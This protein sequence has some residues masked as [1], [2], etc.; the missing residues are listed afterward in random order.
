[1]G[2]ADRIR[3]SLLPHGLGL[4]IV[5]LDRDGS[6]IGT[7]WREGVDPSEQEALRLA[8]SAVAAAA[9]PTERRGHVALPQAG[10]LV[11]WERGD[12]P[13][14]WAAVAM[15]PLAQSLAPVYAM[16]RRIESALA[17]VLLGGLAIATAWAA[18]LSRPS[19]S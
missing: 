9:P 16:R 2:I 6:V 3:Q 18:R 13:T 17:V 14:E 1:M 15:E 19:A 8:A 7:T 5:V 12:E 11:G 4:D 10:M